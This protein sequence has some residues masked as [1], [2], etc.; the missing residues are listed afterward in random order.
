MQITK[1]FRCMMIIVLL[2]LPEAELSASE[3]LRIDTI[4]MAPLGFF[5]QDG[6]TKKLDD[7]V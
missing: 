1:T 2:L 6:M 7:Q 5:A 4:Q 3:L